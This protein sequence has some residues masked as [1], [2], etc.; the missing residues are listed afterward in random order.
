MSCFLL[1]VLG[2]GCGTAQAQDN[3]STKAET[4]KPKITFSSE[5]EEKLADYV[6]KIGEAKRRFWRER[7]LKEIEEIAKVTGL[8][9]DGKKALEIPAQ[10]SVDRCVEGWSVRMDEVWRQQYQNAAQS[11]QLLRVL[12]Q[13]LPQ[14][15]VYA[16]EDFFGDYVRPEEDPA[17]SAAV[18]R[19][20][21]TD[22][23]VAWGEAQAARKQ[24]LDKEIGQFLKPSLARTRDQFS[25][26]MLAKV[27]ELKAALSLSKEREEQLAALAKAATDKSAETWQKNAEKNLFFMSEE[28]RRQVIK[29][30]QFY[31]GLD[32]KDLPLQQAVW[33][34]GLAAL[35]SADEQARLQRAQE[36]QKSRR[37]KVLGQVLVAE[38]D[39]KV[40]FTASQRQRLEPI[41]ER[42]VKGQPALFPQNSSDNYQNFPVQVFFAAGSKADEN[43]LK[44][45]LDATQ[46]KHW[47]EVCQEGSTRVD[48]E[49]TGEAAADPGGNQ[50]PP[51]PEDFEHGI[52]DFLTGK[53]T[54]R[55]KELL[56]P[57]LLKTEDAARVTD[58]GAESIARLQTAARGAAEETLAAWKT[59]TDQYVRSNLNDVTAR[60]VKRRLA[61]MEDYYFRQ[62]SG[63]QPDKQPIWEKTWKAEL[64]EAQQAAWQKEVEERRGYREKIIAAAVVAEFDRKNLL[65]AGQREKIA[66]LVEKIIQDYSPDIANYFTNSDQGPW[67]LQYYSKFI[68]FAGVPE[69]EMKE[70]L[71]KEQWERWTACNEYINSLQYWTNLQANHEQRVKRK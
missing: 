10:E 64:T 63:N 38:L 26:P 67:Y 6:K 5:A 24:A 65:T 2:C 28:Q 61:G 19:I 69:K 37:A 33:K 20:L 62:R 8:N 43:E 12:Q 45:I 47:L 35:L 7:I 16:R 58:L 46:W 3:A 4:A 31:F 49:N 25:G 57:L 17:W 9:P 18:R 27:A 34:E 41:A 59:Q 55:R 13:V 22:Q 11:K 42:L 70:I 51:E 40:A 1:V 68:P 29:R 48:A 54:T 30:G 14:A 60:D 52:S 21:T 39:E 71:S 32:E 36:E 44:P 15:E 66:P 23:M 50:T 53:S 56:A